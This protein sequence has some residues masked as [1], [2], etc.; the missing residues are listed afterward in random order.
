[1]KIEKLL[2]KQKALHDEFLQE[3][4]QAPH[5][6]HVAASKAVSAS[7]LGIGILFASWVLPDVLTET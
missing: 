3:A 7:S 5:P 4:T 6:I 1:M 2:Q